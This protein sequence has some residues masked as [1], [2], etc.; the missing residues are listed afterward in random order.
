VADIHEMI[1]KTERAQAI[2]RKIREEVADFLEDATRQAAS[3]INRLKTQTRALREESVNKEMLEFLEETMR[4]AE[5][6]INDLKR[7][8]QAA[9]QAAKEAALAR[10]GAAEAQSPAA[11]ARTGE[12]GRPVVQGAGQG[13]KLQKKAGPKTRR[14]G[15]ARGGPAKGASTTDSLKSIANN[16][17]SQQPPSRRGQR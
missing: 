1:E 8:R 17:R 5:D 16:R 13:P 12:G 15:G 9:I 11:A 4:I 2:E 6:L 14:A 3:V 10:G 7:R